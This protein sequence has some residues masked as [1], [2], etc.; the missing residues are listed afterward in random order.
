MA[1][2]TRAE[3]SDI[4]LEHIGVKAANQAADAADAVKATDTIDAVRS[5]LTRDDVPA[6]SNDAIPDWAVLPMRDLVSFELRSAFGLSGERLND[7]I[8]AYGVAIRKIYKFTAG[9]HDPH[10]AMKAKYY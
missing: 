8:N 2:K 4:V 10:V 9:K 3:L 5:E 6:W 7:V 1:T